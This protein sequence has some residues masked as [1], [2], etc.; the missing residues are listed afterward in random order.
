MSKRTETQEGMLWTVAD[1]MDWSEKEARRE[2]K[3]RLYEDDTEIGHVMGA[4]TMLRM[5]LDGVQI[6][7]IHSV[8]RAHKANSVEPTDITGVT[9]LVWES[10]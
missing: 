7:D 9:R 5:L 1:A 3:F 4:A 10:Y 2:V 8:E 6:A